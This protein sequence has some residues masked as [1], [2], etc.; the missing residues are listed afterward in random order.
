[1]FCMMLL[2]SGCVKEKDQP[3]SSTTPAFDFLQHLTLQEL[4]HRIAKKEPLF[5]YFGWTKNASECVKLQENYLEPNIEYYR[6]NGLLSVV[7]LDTEMPEALI[8]KSLRNS[9]TELYEFKYAPAFVFFYEGKVQ[10][11]FEW[12]PEMNDVTTGIPMEH[13]NDWMKSVNLIQ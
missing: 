8:D 6:W 5:V 13:I 12:T 2:F 11:Y 1:M 10:S 3:V 4:N 9:L 7:D